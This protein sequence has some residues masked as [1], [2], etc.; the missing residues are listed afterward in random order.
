MKKHLANIISS[1]R[2]L[3]AMVLFFFNELTNLFLVIYCYC[4]L[5]DFVDGR[6]ARKFNSI[7]MLGTRLDT[8]GDVFTYLAL[9]KILYI[10]NIVPIWALIW[11]AITLIGFTASAV[12]SKVRLGKFYFVHSLLGKILGFAIFLLPLAI[13]FIE[14]QIY[15]GIICLISTI[16]A[17]ES[18]VIQ[19]R[20]KTAKTDVL[21]IK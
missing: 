17:A 7:S 4:G 10:K 6:I 16:A 8:A 15:L 20:S 18:V 21:S 1:S 9:T 2:I 13:T 3:C 5:T 19:L 11:F 14:A 12:I